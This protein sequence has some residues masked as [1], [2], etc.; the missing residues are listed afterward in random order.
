MIAPRRLWSDTALEGLVLGGFIAV[1]IALFWRVVPEANA[2]HFSQA[3][4]AYIVIVTLV[5]KSLWERRGQAAEVTSQA[6]DNANRSVSGDMLPAMSGVPTPAVAE[7]VQKGTEAGV[8]EAAA[9]LA[10]DGVIAAPASYAGPEMPDISTAVIAT[11]EEPQW[12]R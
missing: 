9:D 8:K 5:A 2:Q 1:N 3:L 6:L 12:R 11:P 10:A 4:G 7:A